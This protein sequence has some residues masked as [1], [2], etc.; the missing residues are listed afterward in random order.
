MVA[1]GGQVFGQTVPAVG[2]CTSSAC[3]GTGA[4]SVFCGGTQR[5]ECGAFYRGG[6]NS[7]FAAGTS[8]P[9]SAPPSPYPTYS[10][11]PGNAAATTSTVTVQGLESDLAA[12]MK[13][14][15]QAIK[16][17]DP[18]AFVYGW[19]INESPNLVTP[20]QFI[21]DEK[22]TYSCGPGTCYDGLSVH[23]FPGFPLPA[24]GGG[25]SADTGGNVNG[26]GYDCI[27]DLV[28][29]SGLST[30]KMMV[31]ETAVLVPGSAPNEATAATDLTLM[32]NY[33]ASNPNV[34]HINYA[35]VDECSLYPSGFFFD[36]CLI[37]TS[38]VKQLRWQSAKAFYSNP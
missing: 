21:T 4:A 37:T 17:A 16:A 23:I 13:P 2:N 22:N 5:V 33:F 8:E 1:I 27:N 12:Y 6:G 35:N 19:E 32:L 25:C 38:N 3:G 20:A 26:V 18:L 9:S 7:P 24:I 15:Y 34:D 28:T 36:G 29:A 31:G 11:A 30:I 14:C 10:G